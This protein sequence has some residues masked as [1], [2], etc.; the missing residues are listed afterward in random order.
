MNDCG[1]TRDQ[2]RIS[3]DWDMLLSY[4]EYLKGSPFKKYQEIS[5]QQSHLLYFYVSF[6]IARVC[7]LALTCRL[8]C[9]ECI[10][11]ISGWLL[12]VVSLLCL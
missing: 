10:T 2:C 12:L 4:M 11:L 3:A 1:I 9:K 8:H 6:I 5:F 7:S